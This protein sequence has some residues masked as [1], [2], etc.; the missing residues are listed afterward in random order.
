[1]KNHHKIKAIKK[2]KRENN[3]S[4]DSFEELESDNLILDCQGNE[5]RVSI[6]DTFLEDQIDYSS[7]ASLI[8]SDTGGG[9]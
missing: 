1:M 4:Y 5:K 8:T 9:F 7:S 2:E 3:S 6:I